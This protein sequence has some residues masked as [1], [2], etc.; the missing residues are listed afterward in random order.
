MIEVGQEIEMPFMGGDACII[1]TRIPNDQP[2]KE[3]GVW[4]I[5]DQYGEEHWVEQDGETFVT[6]NESA[7]PDSAIFFLVVR[8][9]KNSS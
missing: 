3:D 5:Y 6:V 4:R 9:E 8:G 7:L 1:V 2:A